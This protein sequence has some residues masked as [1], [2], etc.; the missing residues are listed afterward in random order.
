MADAEQTYETII[1]ADRKTCAEV[2]L[3]FES[4]PTW[5]GPIVEAEILTRDDAGRGLRVALGLDMKIRTIRYTL[6]YRYALPEAIQWS[7]VEGDVSNVEG[8]YVLDAL[9]D[10]QTRAICHQSIE[11]GFWV[12]GPLRRMAE[13][14]ALRESVL[15]FATEAVRRAAA[16]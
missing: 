5:S 8:S 16:G 7:L 14:Q 13:R 1:D 4:Y 15:E 10:E 12:P 2:L 9:S 11:L 6:E 3:D